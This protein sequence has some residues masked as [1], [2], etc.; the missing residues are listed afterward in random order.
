MAATI[1]EYTSEHISI[2]YGTEI[3]GWFVN[4]KFLVP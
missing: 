2:E 3:F 4:I 1:Q